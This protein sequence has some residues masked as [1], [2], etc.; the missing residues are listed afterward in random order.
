MSDQHIGTMLDT[1][2]ALRVEHANLP[3][4]KMAAILHQL[5]P[6]TA[7]RVQA[8]LKEFEEREAQLTAEIAQQEAAIKQFVIETGATA[9]GTHLQAIIMVPRVTWD[10]KGMAT[11]AALH[12]DVLAYRKVGEPSVQIWTRSAKRD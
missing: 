6:E 5:D 1:L 4:A 12:P 8:I 3:D 9:Q 2:S 11:Y 10:N 7:E